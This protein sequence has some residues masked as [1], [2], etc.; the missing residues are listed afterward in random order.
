MLNSSTIKF[1]FL[2]KKII[3]ITFF[4]ICI[5]NKIIPQSIDSQLNQLKALRVTKEY[6]GKQ[7]SVD[8]LNRLAYDYTYI[9]PDSSIILGMEAIRISGSQNYGKGRAEALNN[10]ARS[11]YVKGTYDSTL[12]FSEQALT[13]STSLNDT[14]NR[15]ISINNIGLVFIEHNEYKS[16]ILQFQN[17]IL[18]ANAIHNTLHETRALF[19]LG[20]CYDETGQY[21]KAIAQ[22]HIAIEKDKGNSVKQVTALAYDR[23]GKT[24][25]HSKN[26]PQS[27]AHYL[28]VRN[29]KAVNDP[30]ELSFCYGGLAETYF[31]MGEYAKS[32]QNAHISFNY[33]S[34]I[35]AK[36]EAEQALSIL[37]KCYA[38]DKRYDLAY[39]YLQLDK[40]YKD[41][42]TAQN[43]QEAADYFNIQQKEAANQS[44]E[45]ENRLNEQKL[46]LASKINRIIGFCSI[47]IIIGFI[48][49]WVYYRKTVK[50]NT[51]L[52]KKN[53][54]IDHLNTMKDQLFYVISHDL[55]SPMNT[56]QQSLEL[57]NRK[58][59]SPEKQTLL[60]E[61][62]QQQV[63][64]SGKMLNDLL[65]WAA[66][67]QA[68]ITAKIEPVYP[69]KVI[70][71]L[72]TLLQS[73]AERKQI[74]LHM[75][76]APVSLVLSDRDQLKIIIQNLLTNAIKFTAVNGEIKVFFTETD[77]DLLIHIQDNGVGMSPEK[78]AQLFHQFGSKV[79]NPGTER[80]KG[81]GIGLMLVNEFAK[82]NKIK[83]Q[84]DSEEGKGTTFSVIL[85]KATNS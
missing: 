37:A 60:L 78:K 3:V 64:L 54:D 33:A 24:Y 40:L 15:L 85:P 50:L 20:L 68:G 9:N 57:V 67:Q 39:H 73:Q 10:V 29:N 4:L 63:T 26:Y 53:A 11:Y 45:K 72:L 59:L 82:L 23:L 12:V 48:L 46:R 14:L 21:E 6:A 51:L 25:F 32:L 35:H 83:I 74:N 5:F 76:V 13:I 80:E 34:S 55:R 65:A 41:S 42:L 43:T 62:L 58:I 61:A 28:I 30:W 27:I 8:I 44:L 79:S 70:Q 7:E 49:L 71:E 31:A 69:V 1:F 66:T 18:L 36:W 75:D 19:N 77:Q 52:L 17:E 2:N 84:I 81:T 38:L 47:I 16:A 22:L 56:L